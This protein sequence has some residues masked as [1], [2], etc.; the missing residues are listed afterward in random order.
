M[1]L[2]KNIAFWTIYTKYFLNNNINISGTKNSQEAIYV[3]VDKLTLNLHA[4]HA[5][6]PQIL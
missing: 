5:L 4:R 6:R 2:Q 1:L 3:P